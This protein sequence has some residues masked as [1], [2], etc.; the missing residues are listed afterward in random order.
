MD[1]LTKRLKK[2]FAKNKHGHRIASH[3]MS[4]QATQKPIKSGV[5]EPSAEPPPRVDLR[6]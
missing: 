6:K 4:A 5:F 3:G 2:R 1:F